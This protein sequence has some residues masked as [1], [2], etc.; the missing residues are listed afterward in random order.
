MNEAKEVMTHLIKEPIEFVETI[1]RLLRS[2]LLQTN[3]RN[4]LFA[5]KRNIELGMAP[6]QVYSRVLEIANA[7]PQ[8][9]ALLV[10]FSVYKFYNKN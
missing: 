3:D 5:I 10:A 9:A 8:L 6:E 4:I 1:D 2:E 7:T